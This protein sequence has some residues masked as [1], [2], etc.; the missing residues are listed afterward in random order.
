[1]YTLFKTYPVYETT[2]KYPL[3]KTF[4]LP[5]SLYIDSKLDMEY[6]NSFSRTFFVWTWPKKILPYIKQTSYP[7]TLCYDPYRFECQS[8]PMSHN[9]PPVSVWLRVQLISTFPK[10]L[11]PLLSRPPIRLGL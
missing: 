7:R 10:A 9:D 5:S 4:S 3:D 11:E 6:F 2:P 8:F 1:M